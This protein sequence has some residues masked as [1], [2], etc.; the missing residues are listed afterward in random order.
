MG[1]SIEHQIVC[2]IVEKQDF[3]TI[4]KLKIDETYFLGDQNLVSQPRE[5]FKFIRQHFHNE[6]TYGSIPSW[7]IILTRVPGIP[8][9]PSWDE[10]PTLCL[11]LRRLKLRSQIYQLTD[12]L[13]RTADVDPVKSLAIVRE[14][15]ASLVAQHEMSNDLMVSNAY[16]KL[17]QEYQM[18]SEGHGILGIP[19]PWDILNEDTQGIQDGQFIVIYGR[20][21][22]M[23]SWVSLYVATQ[24]YLR[25]KRV[26]IYSLEM[27]PLQM[28][29]RIAAIIC[30]VDYEKFKN[31]KLD[32]ATQQRV[33]ETLYW[34]K[35]QEIAATDAYGHSASLLVT[36]PVGEASGVSQLHAKIR[37]FNPDLVAVDGMY[38]MKDDRG[39]MRTM[40]WKSIAH[41]S[42]DLKKTAQL[43]EIPV[44]GITQANRNAD[45]DPKKADLAEIAYAD[46]VAQDCDLCIRVHKQKDGSS[47]EP[48]LVLSIPG[49]R[50]GKLDA[51]VIH[52]IPA[53]NFCYKRA[54]IVDPNN[55]Q[56][57]SNS[58]G[59]GNSR[60]NGSSR[61]QAVVPT[62]WRM[63]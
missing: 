24:A 12:E 7:E 11:E 31:G 32:P 36:Q 63:T 4:E 47:G 20:P 16:E 62:N 35:A 58:N 61:G 45:K 9:V 30:C 43:F 25:G 22:S 14:A 57:G 46:A 53:V 54:T 48:E 44:I 6:Q 34:L 40:D 59:S 1:A 18:V 39:R 17:Y 23:K 49:S 13:S 8:W 60:G 2:K 27:T 42:Q 28:L 41:I 52:G 50:E 55:P 38:L 3:H 51:L 56:N 37:E 15:A 5:A 21:K 29:R 26:L 33:W 10:L 19:W